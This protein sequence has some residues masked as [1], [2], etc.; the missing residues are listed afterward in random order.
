MPDV[1]W[2]LAE[3]I[4]W[5]R[6]ERPGPEWWT[7]LDIAQDAND[8]TRQG[9]PGREFLA[10]RAKKS[11]RT[12]DRYIDALTGD[13]KLIVVRPAA[14]G[15][16]PVYEIPILFDLPRTCDTVDVARSDTGPVDNTPERETPIVSHVPNGSYPQ[17]ATSPDPTCDIPDPNVR[18]PMHVAP[19][20][21]TPVTT[22]RQLPT[23]PA[24]DSNL[25]GGQL[26]TGRPTGEQ[27]R[28][29]KAL[30]QAADSREIR[31]NTQGALTR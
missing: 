2:R 5:A 17:R 27:L 19:P 3:E 25:E 1:G 8:D 14:P 18:H 9:W 21:T 29:Q 15:R 6:P 11:A 28:R 7:L 13:K 4:A 24:E 20:V 16:R 10:A 12:I 31:T 26:S 30:A 22:T 23:V